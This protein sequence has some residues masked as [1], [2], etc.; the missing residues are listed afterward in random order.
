MSRRNPV[1]VRDDARAAIICQQHVRPS[2][3]SSPHREHNDLGFPS[4]ALAA[5]VRQSL[6]LLG[7]FRDIRQI[8]I[9]QLR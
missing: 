7:H 3:L 9:T 4:M 6:E 5:N 8:F 2:I 1:L